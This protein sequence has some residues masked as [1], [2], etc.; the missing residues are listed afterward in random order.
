MDWDLICAFCWFISSEIS[1]KHANLSCCHQS[2]LVAL[3]SN[4]IKRQIKF[5][6]QTLIV[7]ANI[8]WA[9]SWFQMTIF[10]KRFKPNADLRYIIPINAS[11]STSSTNFKWGY[12]FE[13][14]RTPANLSKNPW[15][16]AFVYITLRAIMLEVKNSRNDSNGSLTYFALPLGPGLNL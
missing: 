14:S 5:N 3:S 12:L 7:A 4:V 10:S 6:L 2:D 8:S 11:I 16:D 9:L 1:R 13:P 15:M